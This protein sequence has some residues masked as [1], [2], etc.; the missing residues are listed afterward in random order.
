[1]QAIIMAAGR[2]TRTY[3]LTLTRPKPLLPVMGDSL[4][5]WQLRAL[6]P[7]VDEVI[8]V[9]GYR[10]AMIRDRFGDRFDTIRLRYVEQVEQRGTG[11]AVLQCRGLTDPDFLVLNGDDLYD[12][13]DLRRLA[14]TERAALAREVADPRP[15]GIYETEPDGRVLRLVEKPTE[16][17]SR[18]ANIGAYRLGAEIFDLLEHAP[19]SPRGEIELTDAVQSLA[20]QRPFYALPAEGYWIPIG[21]PWHLLDANRF[22]LDHFLEPSIHGDISPRAEIHGPVYIGPGTV[23]RAGTVIEGPAWIGPDCR[24]GPNCWI[25]P[26]TTLGRGCVVGHA[27]E[28][29][30]SVFLD[31]ARAPHQN[32]VGDS[33]VG[34]GVNLGCGTITANLRH[35]E[36][37]IRSMVQGTLV[38]T[39]RKKLGAV[40][41]DG[42]H[43]GINTSIY[44]GRKLWPGVTTPPGAVVDRDIQVPDPD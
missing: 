17:F 29:K 33:I 12:P 36:A 38:D 31:G 8:L 2:S 3:P 23:A 35:D 42:V 21:Y 28:V 19:V 44:P 16:I 41:G 20:R 25:R 34:E 24:I 14:G 22:W 43:T 7:I 32:Y 11:H 1:M 5:A 10:G 9:V 15:Y 27:S 13:A 40:I 6:C 18:L 37:A 26:Y 4:L 30:E 39:G